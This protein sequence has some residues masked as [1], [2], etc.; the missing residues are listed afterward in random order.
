MWH[1]I[2][3]KIRGV[4]EKNVFKDIPVAFLVKVW[5]NF[6]DMKRHFIKTLSYVF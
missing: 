6:N 2:S 3:W 5:A 1:S 4:R